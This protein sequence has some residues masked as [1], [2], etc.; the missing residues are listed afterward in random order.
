MPA[1]AR[2]KVLLDANA[3]ML[4]VRARFPLVP[5]VDRIRPGALLLVPSSVL[6][7]L[8]RLAGRGVAGARAA[9]SL[10]RAFAVLPTTGRGDAAIVEAA[11]RHRAWVVTADHALASRLRARGV[12]VLVP[13]DRHRLEL[14]LGRNTGSATAA[15]GAHD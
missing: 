3:L 13:R 5:E 11:V 9:V 8:D 2:A 12:S 10:A 15:S 1:R 14:H 6:A 7:E 4:L